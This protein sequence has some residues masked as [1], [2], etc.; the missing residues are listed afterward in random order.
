A[1][2]PGGGGGGGGTQDLV[3]ELQTSGRRSLFQERQAYLG[4]KWI[5]SQA[6]DYLHTHNPSK[7]VRGYLGTAIH[8]AERYQV[9]KSENGSE[10]GDGGDSSGMEE[11]LDSLDP[12]EFDS[13]WGMEVSKGGKH[14]R[15]FLVIDESSGWGKTQF[16]FFLMALGIPVCFLPARPCQ[17]VYSSFHPL[18]EAFYPS[19]GTNKET[20]NISAAALVRFC[21]ETVHFYQ[22]R[23]EAEQSPSAWLNFWLFLCL[24]S[25][26]GVSLVWGSS[27][28]REASVRVGVSV[29]FLDEV[30]TG[31]ATVQ[32]DETLLP[33]ATFNLYL[34][35][36]ARAIKGKM[37]VTLSGTAMCF[38]NLVKLGLGGSRR[39]KRD[40]VWCYTLLRICIPGVPFYYPSHGNTPTALEGALAHS[41]PV[42]Q[43]LLEDTSNSVSTSNDHFWS[44]V[45]AMAQEWCDVK[46][47][48]TLNVYS[49]VYFLQKS[50][51]SICAKLATT[52]GAVE[53]SKA[54]GSEPLVIFF[55]DHVYDLVSSCIHHGVMS[56]GAEGQQ[57]YSLRRW[58]ATKGDT[59]TSSNGLVPT[60]LVCVMPDP[61][62]GLLSCLLAPIMCP[63]WVD[64]IDGTRARYVDTV[65]LYLQRT[66]PE[67]T[68]YVFERVCQ[69]VLVD[70][71]FTRTLAGTAVTGYSL[72]SNLPGPPSDIEGLLSP[73]QLISYVAFHL[74]MGDYPHSMD[75]RA[76]TCDTAD[77]DDTDFTDDNAGSSYPDT[78]TLSLFYH[79]L[80]H[81]LPFL[82]ERTIPRF[83]N[84]VFPP[85]EGYL[86]DTIQ[87]LCTTM[88]QE[89]KFTEES[90][91]AADASPYPHALGE[92]K[93]RASINK[94]V[95]MEFLER[96]EFAQA[97]G[98]VDLG[99]FFYGRTSGTGSIPYSKVNSG[100]L[101][102]SELKLLSKF[103]F[104]H[105]NDMSCR[106]W[107]GGEQPKTV[108]LDVSLAAIPG[109]TRSE[110]KRRREFER[111]CEMCKGRMLVVTVNV[112]TALKSTTKST[113]VS[114]EA[115]PEPE[116]VQ[117]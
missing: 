25:P 27:G 53:Y 83:V 40:T 103:V 74:R 77:T 3:A 12:D 114:F 84:L 72:Y 86:G 69:G 57:P 21:E 50:H 10:V 47:L 108:S 61:N 26:Q 78:H 52:V 106:V 4:T 85:F 115:V 110:T 48:E 107:N 42:W 1:A 62:R 29:I 30:I 101:D 94:G 81:M 58:K 111:V 16:A 65:V 89:I 109:E 105:L 37:I 90:N 98:R 6:A 73:A 34:R 18:Y 60:G 15:P 56:L 112:L 63:M 38:M 11:F 117:K 91:K 13:L 64:R 46:E 36:N 80:S 54:D 55:E 19:N 33:E 31:F 102:Q 93:L 44:Y 100:S 2:G 17:D 7:D 92:V 51:S 67:L 88:P 99:F 87:K 82:A 76:D 14:K 104:L 96:M 5:E 79:R 95:W 113:G 23:E 35:E 116:D 45:Y 49:P 9:W 70:A 20:T 28:I 68:W 43:G 32:S 75:D 71:S 24:D 39:T 97:G 41:R 8:M 66:H 22:Q 59:L